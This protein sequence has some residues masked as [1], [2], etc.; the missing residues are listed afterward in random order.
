MDIKTLGKNLRIFRTEKKLS[1]EELAKLA[2]V[3]RNYI[4]MIERG[5]QGINISEQI[6]QKLAGGLN[7][8]IDQLLGKPNENTGTIIPPALRKF[9]LEEHL[10]Y[11]IVDT[12][13]QVPFRGKEPTTIEEWKELYAAIK[14][15]ILGEN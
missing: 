1:Q 2:G 9:A 10:S 13:M 8:S 14:H 11:D 7:I 4:S 3:S 12:L 5:S 15:F 6:I